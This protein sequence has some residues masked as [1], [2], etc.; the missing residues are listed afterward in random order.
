MKSKRI[1]WLLVMVASHVGLTW[2]RHA[3]DGAI[4]VATLATTLLVVL[5]MTLREVWL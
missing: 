1:L 5:G 2:S 4:P 3:I